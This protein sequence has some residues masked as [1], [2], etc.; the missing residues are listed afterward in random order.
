MIS[1]KGSNHSYNTLTTGGTM[2][3][4][5]CVN[6]KRLRLIL[7]FIMSICVL[8][9]S[10]SIIVLTSDMTKSYKYHINDNQCVLQNMSYIYLSFT[11]TAWM[12]LLLKRRRYG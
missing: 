5:T 11:V 4:E 2:I 10:L 12:M 7:A 1:P 6:Y 9:V 3:V 8:V